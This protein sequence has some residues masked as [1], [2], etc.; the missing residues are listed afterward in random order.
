MR[1]RALPSPRAQDPRTPSG[2]AFADAV[3]TIA[4]V[5]AKNFR[6]LVEKP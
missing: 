6:C 5:A 4:S 1:T 2:D 3:V